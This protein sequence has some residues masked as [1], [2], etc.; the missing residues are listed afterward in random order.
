M[1]KM[2]LLICNYWV[3]WS[4]PLLSSVYYVRDFVF[5]AVHQNCLY[6]SHIH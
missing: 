3:A 5:F 2:H 6:V 4:S 1:G